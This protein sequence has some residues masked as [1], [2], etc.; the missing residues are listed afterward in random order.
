MVRCK[1]QTE[2]A[3]KYLQLVNSVTIA[4]HLREATIWVI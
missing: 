2:T 4:N 3:N 1:F